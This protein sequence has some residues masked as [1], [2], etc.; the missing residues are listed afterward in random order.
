MIFY[1][2]T[3]IVFFYTCYFFRKKQLLEELIVH[4]SQELQITVHVELTR[5]QKSSY[6]NRLKILKEYIKY[7]HSLET[8]F[9]TRCIYGI[10]FLMYCVLPVFGFNWLID[11]Q[12]DGPN[13]IIVWKLM[14]VLYL[15]GLLTAISISI[16]T[17][18]K[19][20]CTEKELENCD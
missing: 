15:A 9:Y 5:R 2:F 12:K 16:R 19:K 20:Y 8:W 7:A 4:A 18:R 6:G 14:S 10:L 1:T 13:K 17:L 11:L 3:S